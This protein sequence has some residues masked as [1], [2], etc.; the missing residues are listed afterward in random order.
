M[1]EKRTF[2]YGTS[3]NAHIAVHGTVAPS[4]E[5]WQAYL[6]DI[7][8][9]VNEIRGVIVNTAGGGPSAAQRR[10]ATV[11]W[12]RHGSTP[13]MA[14]MTASPVVRGMV[15]TLSWFLGTN[16]RAFAVDR[17]ADA[18]EHLG[19]NEE[20]IAEIKVKVKELRGALDGQ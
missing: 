8:G 4:D 16:V 3:G 5:E 7:I 18:G 14:I 17:F 15:T 12:N 2:V 6:D 19:L 10:I 9:H 20:D 11:H 1:T 13:R